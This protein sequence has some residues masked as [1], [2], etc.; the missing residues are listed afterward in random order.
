M[1]R[2]KTE[3][4]MYRCNDMALVTFLKQNGH[5]VQDVYWE[6]DTETVYWLF[7]VV[8]SLLGLI[9][10][11]STGEARVE[12]REYNRLFQLTKREMYSQADP[13]RH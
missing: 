9:D 3:Q 2:S 7:V 4:E 12:P 5:S 6:V 11:F 10:D 1:A 8:P 13:H